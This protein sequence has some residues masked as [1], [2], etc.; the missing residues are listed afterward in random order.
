MDKFYK[1]EIQTLK[2]GTTAIAPTAEYDNSKDAMIA[3]HNTMAYVMAS[4]AID[5]ALVMIIGG[6]GE[7]IVRDFW[8]NVP[9]AD[10]IPVEE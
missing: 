9:P 10:E 3:Y 7:T 6:T 8:N 4:D 5:T 2:D 1:I